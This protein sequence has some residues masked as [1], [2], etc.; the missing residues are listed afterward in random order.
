M[1]MLA[2]LAA[3][4]LT[5]ALA[6]SACGGDTDTTTDPTTPAVDETTAAAPAP[7][8]TEA[9]E[10]APAGE[11]M[12][13][14]AVNCEIPEG[15]LDA[16]PADLD[17]AEGEITFMTQGLKG[18]FDDFFNKLIA[19]FQAENP[20]TTITWT[21]QGGS[22]DFDT[23]MVTQASNCTMADVINVPSSSILALS[24]G[25]FLLNLDNKLPE[26]GERFV[27]G[28]W[29]SLKLG[30]GDSHTALP[31]YFG[32]FVTTYNKAIFEEAGLDPEKAPATMD[33]YFE[34]AKQITEKTDKYAIY[35][36]TSW[37]LIPQLR[38]YGAKLMNDD[39][40]EFTFASDPQALKWV[41]NMAELYE[42]GGIP[43]DSITGELDMSRAFGDGD[44]A[45][46]T[47]NAS[48][49]RNVQA[50]SPAIYE[51]TGVGEEARQDGVGSL[52]N[53]QFIGVA[54]TT[55]NANLAAKWADYVTSAQNGLAWAKFGIDT[56]TAVVFP[57]T[58]EALEDPSLVGSDTTDP[59]NAAR[60]AAAKG[61][62]DAEAYLPMFY[63]TGAVRQALIN[64]MNLAISG[65][66]EPQAA[67][68]AAQAEMNTLLAQVR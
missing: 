37:Y 38:A 45:F 26:A 62:L 56:E 12:P 39:F 8:E 61:A 27:P 40:T 49:L 29:D 59:F 7:A 22:D 41:T 54:A 14:P 16:T 24:Q 47:P 17:A 43:A 30:A 42:A 2:K 11:A 50:N 65:Q 21:D 25:N 19:D 13:A 64:N 51:V 31:W 53:G 28:V 60:A 33:E 34:F 4:T 6:L 20:G 18:T 55:E 66:A 68:E 15:N 44:L 23:L 35:G 3:V 46:G 67:L 58:T 9:T 52:F 1:K 5:S 36:N 57:V 63:V 48:F 32:P 10:P